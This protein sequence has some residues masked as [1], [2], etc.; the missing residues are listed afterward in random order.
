MMNRE[1]ADVYF[2]I[3]ASG[4]YLTD[5]FPL[6]YEDYSDHELKEWM[7]DKLSDEHYFTDINY[8][9]ELIFEMRNLLVNAYSKGISDAGI[10]S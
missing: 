8:I 7:E 5:T 4:Q 3:L 1:Q 6:D 9:F 2:G 10:S